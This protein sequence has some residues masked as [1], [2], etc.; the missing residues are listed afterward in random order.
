MPDSL[1]FVSA[2]AWQGVTHM[3]PL[4]FKSSKLKVIPYEDNEIN[5]GILGRTLSEWI[6]DQLKGSKYEVSEVIEEDFGYCLMVKRKPYWL[7]VGCSG[8]SEHEYPE[9][10]LSE[11]IA[12]NFPIETIE[13]SVWVTTEMGWLSKI[14][15][16]DNRKAEAMELESILRDKLNEIKAETI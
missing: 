2:A 5:P 6:T 12:E 14:L 9:D 8:F 13:W 16:K 1:H 4:N 15:G 11:E 10:G 3:K 7:W